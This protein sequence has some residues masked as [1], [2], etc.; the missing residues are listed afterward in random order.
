MALPRLWLLSVVVPLLLLPSVQAGVTLRIQDLQPAY[1]P[2]RPLTGTVSLNFNEYLPPEAVLFAYLDGSPQSSTP[3][4][5]AVGAAGAYVFQPVTFDYNLTAA[6]SSN[7]VSYLPERFTYAAEVSG[8]CG[9]AVCQ[10]AGSCQC[11]CQPPYPCTWGAS[12]QGEGVTDGSQGLKF[13]YDVAQSITLPGSHNGDAAWSVTDNTTLVETRMTEAC[14][15]QFYSSHRADRQ[16]WII[17]TLAAGELAGV[18]G[19]A[20]KEATI[21]PFD[22]ASLDTGRLLYGP[23]IPG[24]L[25]YHFPATPDQLI[26]LPEGSGPGQAQWDGATGYIRI[27]NYNVNAVYDIVYLPPNGAKLCGYTDRSTPGGR[28]WTIGAV[29]Q[30]I[31]LT[32][33]TP[34]ARVFSPA[35]LQSLLPPPS[36]P[37]GSSQCLHTFQF[38]AAEE[39]ADPSGTVTVGFDPASNTTSAATASRALVQNYSAKVPFSSFPSLR[40]PS[41]PVNGTL[42]LALQYQG[43]TLGSSPASLV[44]TCPDRDKDGY[45]PE[46]G[47]CDDGNAL[48]YP[49]SGGTEACD[50]KDNDCDGQ[51]DEDFWQ[52]GSRVGDPCGVGACAGIFVCTANGLDTVCNQKV[53]PGE[54]GEYCDNQQDDDCDGQTDEVAEVGTSGPACGCREGEAKACGSTFGICQPGNRVC[55]NGQWGECTGGIQPRAEACNGVDDDCNQVVDDVGG[56][57]SRQ[58]AACQCF[59]GAPPVQETCNDV[60]DNCDGQVDEA[61]VC[62][63]LGESRIC[64]TTLGACEEGTQTCE[65]GAWSA[66]LGGIQP[67][68]QEICWDGLDQ[69]CDGKADDGCTLELSCQNGIQ[70]ANEGGIDCAVD[71]PQQCNFFT[72]YY[73]YL[74]AAGLLVLIIGI[75]LLLR[76]PAPSV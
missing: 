76:P 24:G 75:S 4:G 51:V 52:L 47:D 55:R 29:Q 17:R 73:V 39:V 40:A 8:T 11:P 14:A 53:R 71:C 16:G 56:A 33:A 70:D 27:Y 37:A 13:I 15:Y 7:W 60:D 6:G 69:D 74:I 66:C 2:S 68:P 44:T 54:Q 67:L 36:C 9:D 30:G 19:T 21:E 63:S 58:E 3:L 28:A 49:G 5:G 34:Y 48:I 38:F 59:G 65:G 25:Y 18:P 61:V 23:V 22:D 64:G 57:T 45:C 43:F 10:A 1:A 31:S 35:D 12:F 62:C 20:D 32:Y 26:Y 46:A 50:G 42:S 41:T 72:T